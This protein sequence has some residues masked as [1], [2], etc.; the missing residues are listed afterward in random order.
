MPGNKPELKHLISKRSQFFGTVQHDKH[1][2]ERLQKRLLTEGY[3]NIPLSDFTISNQEVKSA[4][5]RFVGVVGGI[6][7]KNN[8]RTCIFYF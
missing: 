5:G 7:T 6:T 1:E 8:F 2:W 4:K 3:P